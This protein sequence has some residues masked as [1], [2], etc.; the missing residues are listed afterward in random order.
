MF[1]RNILNLTVIKSDSGYAKA[2][3]RLALEKKKLSQHLRILLSE[4]FLLK[5]LYR[6][7]SFLRSEEEKEQFLYHVLSLST[8]DFNC[9]TNSYPT[10]SKLMRIQPNAQPEIFESFSNIICFYFS[11]KFHIK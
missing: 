4:E 9:F 3:I 11:Q 5:T 10:A 7:T 1:S 8:V 2:W 6:R